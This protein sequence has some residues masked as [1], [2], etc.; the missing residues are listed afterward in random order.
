M[1]FQIRFENIKKKYLFI[2]L[3]FFSFFFAFFFFFL[4]YFFSANQVRS[5]FAALISWGSNAAFASSTNTKMSEASKLSKNPSVAG[6]SSTASNTSQTSEESEEESNMSE[7]TDSELDFL[8]EIAEEA[9]VDPDV[10]IC[11]RLTFETE[12]ES[13]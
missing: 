11:D 2:S 9:Q 1:Q 13:K 10:S 8:T 7:D 3:F 4:F 6:T 12:F 5:S